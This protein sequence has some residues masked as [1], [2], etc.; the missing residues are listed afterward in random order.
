MPK[1]HNV[2]T[3]AVMRGHSPSP[4]IGIVDNPSQLSSVSPV[5]NHDCWHEDEAMQLFAPLSADQNKFLYLNA[6]EIEYVY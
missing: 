4:Y 5:C 2:R 3:S 6:M 1:L